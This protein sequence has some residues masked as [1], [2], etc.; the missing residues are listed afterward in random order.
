MESN[1]EHPHLFVWT[2]FS[3]EHVFQVRINLVFPSKVK[4]AFC[5]CWILD[6]WCLLEICNEDAKSHEQGNTQTFGSQHC[7][8]TVVPV[9]PSQM[10]QGL[11]CS[12]ASPPPT[13]TYGQVERP[14]QLADGNE[15]GNW[16]RMWPRDI[17]MM[18]CMSCHLRKEKQQTLFTDIDCTSTQVSLNRPSECG[19]LRQH[20]GLT[21]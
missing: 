8:A 3:G 19:K 15:T 4:D 6:A 20:P 5:F 10:R 13:A 1:K 16:W 18:L 2:A 17:S 7:K 11:R 21:E 14:I 12:R 9:S